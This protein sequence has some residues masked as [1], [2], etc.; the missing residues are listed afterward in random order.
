MP[1]KLRL[2]WA[3]FVLAGFLSL[4]CCRFAERWCEPRCGC[5]YPPQQCGCPMQVCP[6]NCGC[7]AS[8]AAAAPAPSCG[9]GPAQPVAPTTGWSNPH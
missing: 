9:C 6:Q 3:G 2:T 4:G 1:G 5:S 8:P 7:G